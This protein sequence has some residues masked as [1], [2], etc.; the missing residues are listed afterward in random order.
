MSSQW[1]RRAV[2]TVY[3]PPCEALAARGCLVGVD[4]QDLEGDLLLTTQ[5]SRDRNYEGSFTVDG[6]KGNVVIDQAPIRTLS[7]VT[8]N[9]EY[10]ATDEFVN[11]GSRHEGSMRTF[12]TY[13]THDTRI[14]RIGGKLR[15]DFLRT[16]LTLAEI[17]GLID[18]IN[19]FGTTRLVLDRASDGGA[20]RF[21]SDSGTISVTGAVEVLR[22]TPIHAYTQVGRL[23]TNVSQEVL[24][25]VSFSTG[26][27]RTG[28]HGLVVPSKAR[29]DMAQFER[30]AA[31]LENRERSAGLDLISRA[32]MVSILAEEDS[33]P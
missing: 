14:E 25:E 21:L 4:I 29:F 6:V 3:V 28:W 26:R 22:E 15:A 11:S 8:G 12:S 20:Q 31:V 24:D 13:P 19:R 18:V 2:L 32:G 17:R 5:G 33:P 30:P 10:V 9:V 27:P 1:Q 16:D 7:N 23:E